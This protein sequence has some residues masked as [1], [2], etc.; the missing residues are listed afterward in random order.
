MTW[1]Y[2]TTLI[3]IC[4]KICGTNVTGNSYTNQWQKEVQL[5]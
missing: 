4:Q 1:L 2:E 3:P 5:F